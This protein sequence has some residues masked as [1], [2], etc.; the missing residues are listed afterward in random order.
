MAA[1]PAAPARRAPSG[2]MPKLRL[3]E[4]TVPLMTERLQDAGFEVV[5]NTES[6][7]GDIRFVSVGI[8]QGGREGLV[9]LYRCKSAETARPIEEMFRKRSD[10]AVSREGGVVLAATVANGAEGGNGRAGSARRDRALKSS[11]RKRFQERATR[12]AVAA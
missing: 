3:A 12:A 2:T 11:P 5:S 1:G 8:R 7:V 9:Y 4:V 10:A 6:P